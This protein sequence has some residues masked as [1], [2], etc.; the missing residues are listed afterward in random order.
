DGTSK[1]GVV[2]PIRREL[3]LPVIFVGVGEKSDDLKLFSPAQYVD[4]LLGV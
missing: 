1:G 3:N 2:V 4:A